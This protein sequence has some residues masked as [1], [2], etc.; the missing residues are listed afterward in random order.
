MAIVS[1]NGGSGDTNEAGLC[2]FLS[3]AGTILTGPYGLLLGA[4]HLYPGSHFS[5]NSAVGK[6]TQSRQSPASSCLLLVLFQVENVKC[7]V[8]KPSAKTKLSPPSH[9]T[10][11][12][13]LTVK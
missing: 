1:V 6:H 2:V 3:R 4:T 13:F 8:S 10:S 9:F 5:Q 7:S 12:V 11:V